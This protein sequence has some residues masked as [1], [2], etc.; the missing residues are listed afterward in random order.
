MKYIRRGYRHGIL[1]H[2]SVNEFTTEEAEKIMKEYD[3]PSPKHLIDRWNR[4]YD[5]DG[6]FHHQHTTWHYV[7]LYT[8]PN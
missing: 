7:L 1:V 6:R 2:T 8:K 3:V 5:K 4:L